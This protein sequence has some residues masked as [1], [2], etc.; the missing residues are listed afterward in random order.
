MIELPIWTVYQHPRDMPDAYVAR[1]FLTGKP[2]EQVVQ[3]PTLDEV[4]ALIP[5]GLY[6]MPRQPGDDP[7]IVETWF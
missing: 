6:R 7:V 3:A 5:P 4:R 2:T 1:L